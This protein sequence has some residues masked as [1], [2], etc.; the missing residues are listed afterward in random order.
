MRRPAPGLVVPRALL[1]LLF[2]GPGPLSLSAGCPAPAEATDDKRVL[3]ADG[4][5]RWVVT[6]EGVEPDPTEYR[7]LLKT[8]PPEAEE[9]AERMRKQLTRDHA[10]FESALQALSGRV[11]ERWWMSNAVTVEIDKNAAPSLRE[12]AGVKAVTPDVALGD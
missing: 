9:Y 3:G 4:R 11:V 1:A 7:E 8:S 6:F 10:A 12:A 2:L 5:E